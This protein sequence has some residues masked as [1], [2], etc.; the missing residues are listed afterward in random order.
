MPLRDDKSGY[1]YICTPVDDFKVIDTYPKMWIKRISAVFL[2]KSHGSCAYYFGN[3]YQFHD[4]SNAWTYD[5][6]RYAKEA[7]A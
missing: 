3:D 4:S 6:K 2:I 1:A 5:T 7:L